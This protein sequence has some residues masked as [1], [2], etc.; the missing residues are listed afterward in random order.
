MY[1]NIDK[2]VSYHYGQFPP[3]N[4]NYESFIHELIHASE[5]LARFDQ[6]IKILFSCWLSSNLS[7]VRKIKRALEKKY[8][9]Y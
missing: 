2:A 7:T 1:F 9:T 8:P 5:M 6:M 4:I 3:D